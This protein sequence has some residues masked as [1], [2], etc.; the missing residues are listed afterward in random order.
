[1]Q[2]YWWTPDLFGQVRL[3]TM[4]I[5]VATFPTNSAY[6]HPWANQDA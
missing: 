2:S 6:R 1:M 3:P 5:E 4:N